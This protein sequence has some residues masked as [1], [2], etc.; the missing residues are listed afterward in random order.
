MIEIVSQSNVSN[1]KVNAA[2]GYG[3]GDLYEN[4]RDRSACGVKGQLVLH[5]GSDKVKVKS[6]RNSKACVKV[7]VSRELWANAEERPIN[8]RSQPDV[9]DHQLCV[10]VKRK[11]HKAKAHTPLKTQPIKW[12]AVIEK[13][14]V[15]ICDHD[16][17]LLPQRFVRV[18]VE[19]D[20]TIRECA[21]LRG[22]AHAQKA[23]PHTQYCQEWF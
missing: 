4:P 3:Y 8:I 12:A 17:V 7:W 10:D 5:A 14:A 19:C 20:I 6:S 9:V 15:P 11:R 23:E 16:L 2:S 18:V 13:H 1:G 21:G 22:S